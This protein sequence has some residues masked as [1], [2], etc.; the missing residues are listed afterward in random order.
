MTQ[1]ER[2]REQHVEILD[3]IKKMSDLMNADQLR[4]DPSKM[5]EVV[6]KFAG[7]VKL[8]LVMEDDVLY[9]SL[10]EHN[11][12]KIKS[13][14]EKFINELGGLKDS[15]KEYVSK[16]GKSLAIQENPE[17]FIDQTKTVFDLLKNR[18]NNED[19][20]LFSRV[21]STE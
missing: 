2:Y 12:P 10:R 17:E 8:H 5:F 13:L 1:T 6:S 3:I 9:P 15:F 14:A 20:I 16:W 21:D 18:I 4:K 19:N 7:L 11:D